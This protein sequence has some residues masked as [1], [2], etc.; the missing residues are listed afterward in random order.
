[1]TGVI[2]HVGIRV[3]DLH[4]SRRMYE[5]ALAELV[6]RT[7]ACSSSSRTASSCRSSTPWADYDVVL[8]F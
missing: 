7:E 8:R 2:D 6:I 1:M 3:S 4:A 5:T